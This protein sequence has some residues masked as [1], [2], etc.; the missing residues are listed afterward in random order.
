MAWIGIVSYSAY[1]WHFFLIGL[2]QLMMPQFGGV[3][4]V[5]FVVIITFGASFVTYRIIERPGI[6][7]GARAKSWIYLFKDR[8]PQ[9][10]SD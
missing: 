9:T 3:W 1:F 8:Q 2:T 6:R 7:L 5:V 4:H 10:Q